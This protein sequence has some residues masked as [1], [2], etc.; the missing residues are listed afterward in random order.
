MSGIASSTSAMWGVQCNSSN[1]FKI[2]MRL[3]WMIVITAWVSAGHG[4]QL[5]VMRF[6]IVFTSSYGA[7]VVVMRSLSWSTTCNYLFYQY[8]CYH[9]YVTWVSTSCSCSTSSASAAS[10]TP[11]VISNGL[12]STYHTASYHI[13]LYDMQERVSYGIIEYDWE[14]DWAMRKLNCPLP[15]LV[16]LC[17]WET[18]DETTPAVDQLPK[19]STRDWICS[20]WVSLSITSSQTSVIFVI[21]HVYL[22]YLQ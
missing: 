8:S 5:A 7:S 11:P 12:M 2:K 9:W 10:P 21:V 4:V 17:C 13:I 22:P 1:I 19:G 20:R 15:S 18:W 6:K 3:R 16:P 14:Y